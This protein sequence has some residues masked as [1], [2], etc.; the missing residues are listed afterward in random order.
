MHHILRVL[1]ARWSTFSKAGAL[2]R[3]TGTMG[4]HTHPIEPNTMNRLCE[5]N[6][7]HGAAVQQ[8]NIAAAQQREERCAQLH[9]PMQ[10]YDHSLHHFCEE[11]ADRGMAGGMRRSLQTRLMSS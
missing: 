5:E 2:K 10:P 7:V 3:S 9:P 4:V 8:R 11:M 6:N 1:H